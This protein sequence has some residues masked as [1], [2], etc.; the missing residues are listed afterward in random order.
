MSFERRPR[1]RHERWKHF[2]RERF[3]LESPYPTPPFNVVST[4][5]LIPEVIRGL[6]LEERQWEHA[7]IAEWRDLVGKDVA[8]RARPGRVTHG[9]LHVYVRNSIWLSDLQRFGKTQ[10]LRNIQARFG[11]DKIRDLR[12]LLDPDEAASNRKDV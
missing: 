12:F 1:G 9:L 5:T 10:M 6:G 4:R 11:A 3:Q 2:E 7:L 8:R